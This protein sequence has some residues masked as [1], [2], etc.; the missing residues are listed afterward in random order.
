MVAKPKHISSKL[1]TASESV[2]IE[3]RTSG[4]KHMTGAAF[5]L[6]LMMIFLILAFWDRLMS[7]IELP[8][9]TELLNNASY[10]Q[11][12]FIVL[13]A[14][15]ALFFLNFIVKYL[16]WTSTL[17]VMTNE[18]VITKKGILGR[19]YEDMPLHM[20]TNIDVSQSAVQR[21]LGYGTVVFSSQSGTRD[22]VVWKGVPD[23]VRVRRK[24][25]EAMDKRQ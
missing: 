7:N 9:V 21:F 10:R 24:V 4:V 19:N 17:Y 3:S 25:Q 1:L 23:P 20:I 8:F 13:I 22:D 16:R 18:R 15:A 12:F 11:I 14:I 5:S 6:L 2:L